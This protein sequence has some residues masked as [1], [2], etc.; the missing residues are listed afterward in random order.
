MAEEMLSACVTYRSSSVC[1]ASMLGD[2]EA[3][4]TSLNSR[5]ES[6]H[7][8]S[9]P[10]RPMARLTVVVSSMDTSPSKDLQA[11]RIA[12][13]WMGDWVNRRVVVDASL[14]STIEMSK[15]T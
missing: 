10:T 1:V 4:V 15:Y 7:S 14:L 12:R 6:S 13:S 11:R 2:Q 5:M 3:C 9:E 8:A